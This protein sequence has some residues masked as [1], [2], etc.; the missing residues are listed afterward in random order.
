MSLNYKKTAKGWS[1][2]ASLENQNFIFS[3]SFNPE[4]I[5]KQKWKKLLPFFFKGQ[6]KPASTGAVDV[7]SLFNEPLKKV[8]DQSFYYSLKYKR[9]ICFED[10]FLSLLDSPEIGSLFTRLGPNTLDIKTLVKSFLLLSPP[11]QNTELI[12]KLPFI[13]LEESIKLHLPNISPTLLLYSLISILPNEHFIQDIILNLEISLDDLEVLIVWLKNSEYEF[14]SEPHKTLLL[15]ACRK[16]E[17]IEKHNKCLFRYQTI[18]KSLQNN[19]NILLKATA[20]LVKAALRAK[21]EKSNII[22]EKHL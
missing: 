22:K 8:W 17:I 2:A 19:Q 6:E 18:K 12:L 20:N 15:A 11:R 3:G 1:L 21:Q 9:K 14:G 5:K 10:I 7:Y 4:R 13:A 16:I